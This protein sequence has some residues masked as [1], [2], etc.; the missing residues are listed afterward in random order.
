MT[1]PYI[2]TRLKLNH[3]GWPEVVFSPQDAELART[4]AVVTYY[5][6]LGYAH[7]P[8][9]RIEVDQPW[10]AR[11]VLDMSMFDIVSD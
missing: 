1:E 5:E 10:L 4:P 8:I 7:D 9:W 2:G 11:F 3:I 6:N